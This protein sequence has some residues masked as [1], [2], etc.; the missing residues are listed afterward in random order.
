MAHNQEMLTKNNWGD[1]VRIVGVS[2][3]DD[4]DVI[5]QRVESK[6]WQ[7][8]EHLTL[9][10]WDGEH[11]LIKTFGVSG[12]PFVALTN[13]KGEIVFTGHPSSINLEEKINELIKEGSHPAQAE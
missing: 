4:V 7:K 6:G 11:R 9:N 10:G 1:K 2:V 12:I 5:K 8:V 13:T 3:D